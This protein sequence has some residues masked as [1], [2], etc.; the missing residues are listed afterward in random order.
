MKKNY[1]LFVALMMLSLMMRGQTPV[2]VGSGSYASF[3]PQSKLNKELDA[4]VNTIPI[5]VADSKK[6]EAIPTNDWWTD[7]I[8]N[9]K[10]SGALWA[11]PMV[12]DAENTGFK[13][14]YP[15]KMISND[16]DCNMEYGGSMAISAAGYTP[17]KAIAKDWS[18]WGLVM[19]MPD[20][21]HGKNIDV[22]MAHGVP[23]T[24]IETHGVS[25]EFSFDRGASFISSAGT[26]LTFP[27]TKSFVV[28]T[29]GRYF[30]VHLDG[31]STAE[32]KGQQFAMIDLGAVQPITQ[33]KLNW[34]NAYASGYIIQVSDDQVK[35]KNVFTENSS[36]G[37]LDD[38]AL[39]ASG[40]YVK[41]LFGAK[42]TNFGYSI[43]E[44]Q[45]FNGESLLSENKPATASSVEGPFAAAN[46][47]D[48]NFGSRWAS[49]LNEKERLVLTTNAGDAFLVV[50]ALP[51]AKDLDEYEQYAFNKV[52]GTEFGYDYNIAA[53]K[54]NVTWNIKT[55]NL[56]GLPAGNTLQGFLPHLYED[57]VHHIAFT[58][59][60]YVS[61]HGLIKT[62]IGSSFAFT[63]D[64]GG[65]LPGYTAPYSNPADKNPYKASVMYDLV[66]KYSRRNEFSDDTY[67][68]GKNLV[69]AAKYT[70]MAKELNHQA[71]EVIKAQTR[72]QLVDWLTYSPGEESRFF[73]RYDRWGGLIGFNESYGSAQFTD[74]H[75]HYGYLTF[76]CALYG[77]ADPEF[78]TQYKD[79]IKLVAKEYANWDRKDTSLPYFR[80]LDPWIGHSYAGGTSSASGNNQE[81]SS[82]AM[83]SWIGL[84][85]IGDMTNDTEMR[86]A[87]AFGYTTESFAA[88]E[89]WFDWK[90][91]VF[92]DDYKYNMSAI[93]SNQGHGHKIFFE[94]KSAL[95]HGIEYLPVS[96]GLKYLA[97]DT[98][99]A[100]REYTDLKTELLAKDNIS[101]VKFLGKDWANVVLGFRQ[102][103]DPQYVAAYIDENMKMTEPDST[104]ILGDV[105]GGMTYYYTHAN[106]NLGNFSFT[107]HT[108]FPSSSV[109]EKDGAFSH[110]V[111]YNPGS[112]EKKCNVYDASGKVVA[113]FTVP[114]LTLMTYPSLPE[115]GQQPADCY[116]VS[117][118]RA[119][120]T[121]G[122][123]EAAID[124]NPGSR[125]ESKF[126][127]PQSITLNLGV[128]T[129]VNKISISWE[130]ANAKNYK[131]LASKD[132]LSWDTLAV[133]VNMPEDPRTDFIDSIGGKP[134]RFIRM[135]G[136]ERNTPYGYSIYEFEICGSAAETKIDSVSNAVAL[137]AFI[138]AENFT[139]MEGIQTESTNDAAGGQNIGWIDK[140]D[141]LEYKV[142]AA[143][144]G[145]F[146]L[147][148]RVASTA[149]TGRI[150]VFSDLHSVASLA[151]P[152]TGD[153]QKY[154]TVTTG[155]TLPKG[156]QTLRISAAEAPFNFNWMDITEKVKR[157]STH[158]EAE[159]YSL[160]SGIQTEQTNDVEGG[161]N[162]GYIDEVDW[163]EYLIN[164]PKA[165]DYTVKYRV[166]SPYTT[167]QLQ[168]FAE[169]AIKANSGIPKTGDFQKFTTISVVVHFD[170][171]GAQTIRL[172]AV[173]GG[174]NLNWLEVA[175]DQASGQKGLNTAGTVQKNLLKNNAERLEA[176]NILTPN[177]D[178]VNDVWVVKNTEAFP[179]NMVKI[180]DQSGKLVYTKK[181]YDNTWNGTYNG[182]PL[183]EGTYYY[184]FFYGAGTGQKNG[185]ITIVRQR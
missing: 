56:K 171:A 84:F 120:A 161:L 17:D 179:G 68:G 3:P 38:I 175:D 32:V 90:N 122:N 12:V 89:Y 99:W 15:I 31:K 114:A 135:A 72:K 173:G 127:D 55:T 11:S 112:A 167:G 21:T 184:I 143:N 116:A 176:D 88:L 155:L 149:A 41:I 58:P 125:W 158:I 129:K 180:F 47:N 101:D 142:S 96:P 73:A 145:E 102:L 185:F 144:A 44:M 70:L 107:Y 100:K 139:K 8:I 25:P 109:F 87:G 164:I 108:D 153:W 177:G 159:D 63:Y 113:S 137:P 111:V 156:E 97:R 16:A 48:G 174:F 23:F 30:G 19:S 154:A 66:T 150:N 157:F 162:A 76:A 53:G 123:P 181:G 51:A 141:W 119:Y 6:K 86:K 146:Q 67:W 121:S 61:S 134:Y 65:V 115:N 151:V 28:Q 131:I 60:S 7:L 178:G 4:F 132:S 117:P 124:G 37:E 148:L 147:K 42:A 93:V 81:S 40:R 140:G 71:Y 166:A 36:N 22:T 59:H 50:S 54:V 182:N 14:F 82:E 35:W 165:G 9:G 49:D 10:N 1:L 85:L 92:P 138:E 183:P 34:E 168:F 136:T 91:R 94:G 62:S 80:T 172:Q 104:K 18:D 95:I 46:I 79:M 106:Q 27:I 110:A 33:I 130:K 2:T 75:F 43:F 5:Y 74:N 24:W 13:I 170:K 20:S 103:W 57:A 118:V 39:T 163:M 52:T 152:N 105:T 98:A 128:L 64:F 29:D 26:A 45:V 83:Q 77:M 133:K 160:M 126:E 69:N 169:N 78:L